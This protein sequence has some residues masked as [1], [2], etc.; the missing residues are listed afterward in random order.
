MKP[1][2]HLCAGL[3]LG[4]DA[5]RALARV[6]RARPGRA[7]GGSV[8]F[9]VD[10]HV[11]AEVAQE[12]ETLLPALFADLMREAVSSPFGARP[13]RAD[14]LPMRVADARDRLN[15]AARKGRRSYAVEH[16]RPRLLGLAIDIGRASETPGNVAFED[17][18]LALW[19]A[20]GRPLFALRGLS[21]TDLEAPGKPPAA[22][23]GSLEKLL[24]RIPN[25]VFAVEREVRRL[26]LGPMPTE[27]GE[28]EKLW[29]NLLGLVSPAVA[30]MRGL[31]RAAK[32]ERPVT[33]PTAPRNDHTTP[34]LAPHTGS[35]RA[36]RQVR[37]TRSRASPPS[38]TAGPYPPRRRPT[39]P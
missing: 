21:D 8:P 35:G 15:D 17:A 7:G 33:A 16:L 28:A 5:E 6:L 22:S 27:P 4:S 23:R 11:V 38:Q 39:A 1:D 32:R 12:A 9:S 29:E 30:L 36:A 18:A 20:L 3:G 19:S 2:D 13:G 37:A 34:V 25:T 31:G 26:A 10:D 24:V 14:D